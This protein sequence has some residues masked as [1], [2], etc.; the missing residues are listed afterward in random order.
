MILTFSEPGLDLDRLEET[1]LKEKFYLDII[2]NSL[3]TLELIQV[4]GLPAF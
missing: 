1:S 2:K 3:I 4:G